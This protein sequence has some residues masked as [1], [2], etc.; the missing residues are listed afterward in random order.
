MTLL[1][2]L[3][4]LASGLLRLQPLDREHHAATDGDRRVWTSQGA[5]N[6]H[7]AAHFGRY[8]FKPVGPLA[9][10]DP[11]VDEF[12]G[13]AVWLEAHK[14]NEAQFRTARDGTL[15]A[16]M[17]RLS[18]AFVL[19]AILP[20]L[21][22]LLGLSAFTGEREAGTLPQLMS[23]GLRPKHLLLG[24]GIAG[25][26]VLMGLLVLSATGLGAGLAA[27]GPGVIW[28][29]GEGVRFGGLFAAYCAYL[30]GFLALSLA[31]SARARSSRAALAGLLGFWLANVFV[32][33]RLA[34][35]LVRQAEPLPTGQQFRAGI[36][37]ARK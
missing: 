8:A 19:Q 20:L 17:V 7:S 29:A 4:S 33:P 12:A 32:V 37:E 26:V 34:T 13:N 5:K 23:L 9:V 22:I 11:G 14:Q 28:E 3:G 21:A 36:A 35:D 2:M 6:P 27:F 16:R 15:V 18:L 30:T 31:A 24:K 10:A 1:L 25:A